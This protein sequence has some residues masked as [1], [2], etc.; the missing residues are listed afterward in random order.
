M[1]DS[2]LSNFTI[3]PDTLIVPPRSTMENKSN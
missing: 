2:K 3:L 1:R